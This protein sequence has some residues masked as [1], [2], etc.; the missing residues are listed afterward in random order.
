MSLFTVREQ[1]KEAVAPFFCCTTHFLLKKG[2]KL[3]SFTLQNVSK[4]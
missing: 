1:K 2:V 3:V 4:L